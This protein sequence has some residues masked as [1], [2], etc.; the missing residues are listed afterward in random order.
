MVTRTLFTFWLGVFSVLLTVTSALAQ[1]SS[2]IQPDTRQTLTDKRGERNDPSQAHSS[3]TSSTERN[4][5]TFYQPEGD[6][7]K[8]TFPKATARKGDLLV[9][10]PLKAKCSSQLPWCWPFMSS[11]LSTAYATFGPEA[12]KRCNWCRARR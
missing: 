10:G 8:L 1:D 5:G 3:S 6:E 12:I 9:S 11:A 2:M 7:I 4:R